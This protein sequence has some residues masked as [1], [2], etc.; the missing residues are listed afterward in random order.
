MMMMEMVLTRYI[1]IKAVYI[2]LDIFGYIW[3]D[4]FSVGG[5]QISE[6]NFY[7]ARFSRFKS[8]LQSQS[9][10]RIKDQFGSLLLF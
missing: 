5:D 8:S 9:K 2:Y 10:V 7:R 3:M 4:V 1:L 6:V